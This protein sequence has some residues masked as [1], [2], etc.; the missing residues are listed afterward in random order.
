MKLKNK[1]KRRNATANEIAKAILIDKLECAF[2]YQDNFAYRENYSDEFNAEIF[3]HLQKHIYAIG[4][5]LNPNNDNI[6]IYY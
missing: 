3:K 1:T 6:E 4:K 2:Y 5:K